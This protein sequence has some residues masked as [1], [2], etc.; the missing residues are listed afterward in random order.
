[1]LTSAALG[2]GLCPETVFIVTGAFVP[3]AVAGLRYPDRAT[4]EYD[5]TFHNKPR[6]SCPSKR[7]TECSVPPVV[8]SQK[9]SKHSCYRTPFRLPNPTH[10]NFPFSQENEAQFPRTRRQGVPSGVVVEPAG[11]SDGRSPSGRATPFQA[12]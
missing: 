5:E 6:N 8:T 12:T 9:L 1:M 11:G 7:H 4:C 2:Y 3:Y 10:T